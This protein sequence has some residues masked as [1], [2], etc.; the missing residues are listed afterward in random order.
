M[1]DLKVIAQ[2]A[3]FVA[4]R[5]GGND[6]IQAPAFFLSDVASGLRNDDGRVTIRAKQA[7]GSPLL[8]CRGAKAQRER[9]EMRGE[10]RS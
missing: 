5:A 10:A 9:N 6:P 1:L 2:R 8:N 4:Q 3:K 7:M